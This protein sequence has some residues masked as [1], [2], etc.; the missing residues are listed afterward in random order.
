[1]NLSSSLSE[2]PVGLHIVP[3]DALDLLA[4]SHIAEFG[5]LLTIQVHRRPLSPFD[6]AIKRAFDLFAATIG[7]ISC[8][9]TL[10][11]RI[12]C[13]K[14]RFCRPCALPSDPPWL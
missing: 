9:T 1:M 11:D 12:D 2:L 5:D 8:I 6:L 10:T 3:V 13:H 7:L 14:T 4:G